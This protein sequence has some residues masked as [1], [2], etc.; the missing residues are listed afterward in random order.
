M[1]ISLLMM[2]LAFAMGP[3][4]GQS[5]ERIS[6]RAQASLFDLPKEDHCTINGREVNPCPG[7]PPPPPSDPPIDEIRQ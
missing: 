1:T 7:D 5:I 4:T 2:I 3:A 6:A